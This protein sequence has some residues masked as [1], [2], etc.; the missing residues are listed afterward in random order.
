VFIRGW[1]ILVAALPRCVAIEVSGLKVPLART[2]DPS[3]V[4]STTAVHG[5][6]HSNEFMFHNLAFIH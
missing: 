2:A 6:S 4:L 1:I 3:L 5:E